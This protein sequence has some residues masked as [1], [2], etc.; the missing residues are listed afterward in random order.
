MIFGQ[1]INTKQSRRLA[2]QSKLL[3]KM[4][5]HRIFLFWPRRIEN[6]QWVW[7]QSIWRVAAFKEA[8]KYTPDYHYC[9][10]V[11]EAW[12]ST[13]QHNPV[14]RNPG[15]SLLAEAARERLGY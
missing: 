5:P 11:E 10:T 3:D 14:F 4:I 9:I 12:Q 6:Q 15:Y 1:D 13:R 7:L 8:L 2:K